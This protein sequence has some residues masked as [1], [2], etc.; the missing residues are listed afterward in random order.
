M[1][2]FVVLAVLMALAA[3]ALVLFGARWDRRDFRDSRADLNI[4]VLRQQLQELARER[5]RGLITASEFAAQR[6]ELQR[7][8]LAEG[9]PTGAL[10][11]S[12]SS[13]WPLI[14]SAVL[15]PVLAAALYAAVGS[16]NAIRGA[17][18]RSTAQ[19]ESY[20]AS[21]PGDARAW[22]LLARRRMD[23]DQFELACAAYAR[24]LGL[25]RKVAGDPQVWA[26]YADALG[27]AQAG[28]LAGKPKEAIGRALALDPR[29]PKALE[30]AGSAAYEARD[31]RSAQ[32]HWRALLN[33]LPPDSPQRL[34]LRAAV[35]RAERQARLSLPA[36]NVN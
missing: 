11:A 4:S 28:T 14:A 22:V 6:D 12:H 21:S 9:Q 25:S 16:P 15:V 19:L 24:A 36:T 27:M 30:L 18:E 34:P 20:A 17:D 33:L 8:L 1:V 3:V 10:D 13:R 7:R 23:A 26:E 32:A 5:E 2:T 29:H 31:F 35:Q